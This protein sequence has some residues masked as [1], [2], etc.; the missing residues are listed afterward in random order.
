[1]YTSVSGRPEDSYRKPSDGFTAEGT[2]RRNRGEKR[3]FWSV[4]FFCIFPLHSNGMCGNILEALVGA[5][6][7]VWRSLVSRLTGGQEAAGSSPVTRTIKLDSKP[8]GFGSFCFSGIQL[9]IRSR[10]KY[11]LYDSIHFVRRR[12][13]R[14]MEYNFNAITA[15]SCPR[16]AWSF[17]GGSS[18]YWQSSNR[19]RQLSSYK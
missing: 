7:R 18:S 10:T 5:I 14:F 9:S 4:I 11:L 15:S 19:G 13:C 1:M 12:F 16:N 3:S 6:I 8:Q 2:R 17:L